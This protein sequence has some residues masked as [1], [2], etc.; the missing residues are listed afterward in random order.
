MNVQT[1]L[2]DYFQDQP[3]EQ[4]ILTNDHEV[5]VSFLTLGA[6]WH[7]FNVPTNKGDHKNLL[8]NFPHS[9][10]YLNNPFYVCM[11]IGRTG[12]RIKNGQFLLNDTLISV[13]K[14]EGQ[15]TLHGGPFGFHQLIW[16]YT[17]FTD[18]NRVGVEF[19]RLIKS[20]EDGYPGDLTATIT[21]TLD[22]SNQ[23]TVTFT[24][25]SDQDTLFNP[26]SHAYFN[27]GNGPN[28]LSHSL[29]VNSDRY[30][31]VD[32]E[33]VPTGK[34]HSVAN[35]PFDFRKSNLLD[36]A[37]K[38]LETT[39]EKGIDDVFVVT[40]DKNQN[41]ATLKDITSQRQITI[42]S[43]RNGLVVFTANSFTDDMPF[44]NSFGHPYKGIALEPQTLPDAPNHKNF[45]DISLNANQAKSYTIQYCYEQL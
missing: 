1:E 42:K 27:L 38:A 26:T 45:G 43:S 2:F 15:N 17:T 10:D 13:P 37:I 18:Q 44:S 36:N 29:Q 7:T 8:L 24:G 16:Q 12:G 33:K 9:A 28:I 4:I 5:S 3:I 6:T 11:A 41:I 30:L 19:K 22:N 23:V 32:V 34:Y 39:K 35:T 20:A 14:N 25:I 40:P 21:Y 31:D